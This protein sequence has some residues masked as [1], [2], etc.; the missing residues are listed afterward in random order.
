MHGTNSAFQRYF[1]T[2][3][4]KVKAVYAKA[5]GKEEEELKEPGKVVEGEFN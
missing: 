2:D 4:R 5:A 1:R 3:L